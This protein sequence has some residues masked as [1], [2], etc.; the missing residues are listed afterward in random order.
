MGLVCSRQNGARACWHDRSPTL[1][2]MDLFFDLLDRVCN[3]SNEKRP[4][5]LDPHIH[6]PWRARL[7]QEHA[8]VEML[9][10][11]SCVYPAGI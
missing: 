2:E 11:C 10:S 6:L 9:T 3:P 5:D 8:P 1:G 4:E 7:L